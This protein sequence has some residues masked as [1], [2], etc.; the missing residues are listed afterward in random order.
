VPDEA[1]R[2]DVMPASVANVP[3]DILSPDDASR[4]FMEDLFQQ[5]RVNIGTRMGA[6]A[7]LR[8]AS[9]TRVTHRIVT[10]SSGRKVLKRD[11]FDCGFCGHGRNHG[12]AK[13]HLL[14]SPS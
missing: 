6:M 10:D 7:D 9:S 13:P 1:P 12:T 8:V 5:G 4:H 3:D 14:Q 11:H 2:F